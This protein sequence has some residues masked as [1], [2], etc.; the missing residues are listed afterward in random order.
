MESDLGTRL[1]WI[2]IAHWNT[3]KLLVHLVARGV[4]NDGSDLVISRDYIS[5]GLRSRV[6]DLVSAELGPGC[7]HE[8]RRCAV[9]PPADCRASS[10][11][12]GRL[13]ATGLHDELTGQ[14]YGVDGR[15]YRMEA[16]VAS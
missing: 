13:V 16:R 9:S 3:D 4:A 12:I 11:I 7:E 14:A 10:P 15:A 5:H 6:T 2:S 1:D 8:I